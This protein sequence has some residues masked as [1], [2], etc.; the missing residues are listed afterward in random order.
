[1]TLSRVRKLLDKAAKLCDDWDRRT[2]VDGKLN[3][4]LVIAMVIIWC[5]TVCWIIGALN[6]V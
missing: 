1:M 6:A 3:P 4:L 5:F 2:R